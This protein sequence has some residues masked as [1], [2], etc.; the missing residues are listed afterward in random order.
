MKNTCRLRT[1]APYLALGYLVLGAATALEAVVG[2]LGRP[3]P[4]V[5][6]RPYLFKPFAKRLQHARR[7][8]CACGRCTGSQMWALSA[9][10][11]TPA[12]HLI[13]RG[14]SHS[15]KAARIISGGPD[16]ERHCQN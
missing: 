12:L 10:R 1:K 16:T 7:L 8:Q 2:G 9:T 11:N 6:Q 13:T 5:A 4:E 15:L 3:A 14:K